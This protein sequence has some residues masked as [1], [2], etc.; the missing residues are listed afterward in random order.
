MKRA[1]PACAVLCSG[2]D[3][4]RCHPPPAV[5]LL[6]GAGDL[7]RLGVRA[8]LALRVVLGPAGAALLLTCS[9]PR[10]CPEWGPVCFRTSGQ[11]GVHA[12]PRRHSALA[13]GEV[14]ASE[15][16]IMLFSA[17]L[18]AVLLAEWGPVCF[19]RRRRC[20]LRR[21]FPPRRG[22]AW[23]LHGAHAGARGS[24]ARALP[25]RQHVVRR[26]GGGKLLGGCSGGFAAVAGISDSLKREEQRCRGAE[27][28]KY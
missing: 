16:L 8:A 6:L 21:R 5:C 12:A 10:S 7:A 1:S 28:A 11:S 13:V 15:M 27:T 20:L 24:F 26:L 2:F 22:A 14:S 25:R 4:V 17:L 9:S 19:R 23:P 18:S 3:C